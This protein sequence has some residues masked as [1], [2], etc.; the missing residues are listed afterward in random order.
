[1]CTEIFHGTPCTFSVHVRELV[2]NT[3]ETP[4]VNSIEIDLAWFRMTMNRD[5]EL[6][7]V[8]FRANAPVR[9][10]SF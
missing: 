7:V 4:N 3:K 6:Q 5:N 1:M 10:P 9:A 2:E 8:A